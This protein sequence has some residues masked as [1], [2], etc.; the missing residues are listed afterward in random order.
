MHTSK[1][2]R[3]VRVQWVR[4]KIL[5][6][7]LKTKMTEIEIKSSGTYPDII[8]TPLHTPLATNPEYP[9]LFHSKSTHRT[10]AE[11]TE[12]EKWF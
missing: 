9:W 12:T 5:L 6:V 10:K 8:C 2:T 1:I 7:H 11:C 3:A 4:S